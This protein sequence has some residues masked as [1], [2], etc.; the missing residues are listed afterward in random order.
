VW[1]PGVARPPCEAATEGRPYAATNTADIQSATRKGD[2]LSIALSLNLAWVL[3]MSLLG[4]ALPAGVALLAGRSRGEKEGTLSGRLLLVGILALVV[5]FACGFS[6]QY[7]GIHAPSLGETPL[8]A[9]EWTP[10]GEGSGLLSWAGPLVPAESG[11]LVLFLFQALGAVTVTVLALAPVSGRMPGPGLVA[12]ALFVGGVLYPLLG[13]W[14]WGGGWLAATGTTAYLGHGLVDWGGAGVLY[15]LGGMLGLAGLL[16][17]GTRGDETMLEK[18]PGAGAA[19]LATLGVAALNLGAGWTLSPNLPLILANTLLSAAAAAVVAAMYM[20]FTTARFRVPMVGRGLLAGAAA[21]A[22]LAP[23]APPMTL[24]IIGAAA[25]LLACLGSFLFE[26][27]WRLD[28][29]GGI[30]SSFGLG[31]LWGLLA[32]G[33]FSDGT[34]G[35][36]LNGIGKDAYLGV[37]GQGVSGIALLAP[38][39]APDTGQLIAQVLG[40]LVIVVL[41][42]GPGW[43]IFRLG[44]IRPSAQE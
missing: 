18:S 24:L 29:R 20:A 2:A 17:T 22:G 26:R 34:L 41:A 7:G 33:L 16:A 4:L 6:L 27:I 21:S 35:Q 39:L 40:L 5:S 13:H 23:Y 43:L 14:A 30:A 36:G 44:S 15:G 8:V 11:R 12:A 1:L 10:L 38:G 31:G 3:L 42:L 25:G 32:V 28:D 37:A 19:L 9:W